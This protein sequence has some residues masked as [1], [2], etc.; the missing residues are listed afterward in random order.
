MKCG[1][2]PKR[3][4]SGICTECGGAFCSE[5]LIKFKRK[6]ICLE[7]VG[8]KL[9]SAPDSE[10]ELSKP[11]IQINQQQVAPTGVPHKETKINYRDISKWLI[12]FFLFLLSMGKFSKSG[13]S[14]LGGIILLGLAIYWVP[15]IMAWVQKVVYKYAGILLPRWFRIGTSIFVF[16][17]GLLL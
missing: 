10:Q 14:I 11:H 4:A 13:W 8:Q 6:N 1:I 16:F 12:A 7:C 2:H 9:D 3:V 15:P 17:V 5:C